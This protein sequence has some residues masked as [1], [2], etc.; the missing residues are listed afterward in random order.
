VDYYFQEFLTSEQTE[1]RRR[2]LVVDDTPEM[3]TALTRVLQKAG[4]LVEVSGFGAEAVQQAL[5]S[6]PDLI[7]LH[8]SM[9]D[10]DGW[11]ATR[12]IAILP[13]LQGVPIVII[14]GE[15]QPVDDPYV[16]TFGAHSLLQK[17]VQDDVLIAHLLA[18]MVSRKGRKNDAAPEAAAPVESAPPEPAVQIPEP[19]LRAE[20]PPKKKPIHE[21]RILVVDDSGLFRKRIIHALREIGCELIEA[22]DGKQACRYVG[23]YAPDLVIMDI[24]MPGMSGLEA[25]RHIRDT[26]DSDD[27]V[28]IALTGNTQLEDV[29]RAMK[30]GMDDY[31]IKPFANHE[32]LER[33]RFHLS[34]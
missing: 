32:L 28:I 20:E 12:H 10:L 25:A 7:L 23:R 27:L 18:A 24:N 21:N 6:V 4:F 16:R 34:V 15:E 22:V 31:I 13:A 5:I 9:P 2:V 14:S 26:Y 3:R 11:Q 33:V 30:A 17:P 8:I 29:A 1:A 19:V